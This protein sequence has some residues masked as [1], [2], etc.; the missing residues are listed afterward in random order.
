M[1]F[2][3][4]KTAVKDYCLL[5][6]TDADTRVG[7]AINRHYRRVTSR[8]GLDATR[9]VT[10]SASMTLGVATVTFTEI[11]KIAR[12][13]DTTDSTAIRLIPEVSIHD[14]RVTQPGEA[15]P[16][17]WALQATDADSVVIRTDTVPQFAWSLQADGWT[18]LS[19]LSGTDEPAFPESFHDIL[20]WY[21]IA[22]EM[23]KKEKE[24]LARIYEAKAEALFSDLQFYLA[25]SPTRDTQQ[26]M[27]TVPLTGQGGASG[28]G[29]NSGSTSYTQSG[30]LTFDRGAGIAPFVVAQSDA[31]YVANLG[32]EFLGNITTDRLIGRDTA[33]T[34]ESEQLTVGG[35]VEFTGSGG[36]QRSALTGDVTASAGSGATTIANLA[37]TTGKLDDLAVST[38]KI[39]A[40][41]VTYAKIQN[42]SATSR[43][44]GR[45]TSG[46]GD[47]EEC[48][49]SEVL[50]FISSAAQ[51]D[52]LYRGAS[53][54]ARLGA[55]TALQVLQTQGASANPQWGTGVVTL[56]RDVS[57]NEVVSTAAETTVYSYS[58]AGGT[59]ST[60]RSVRVTMIG[61][62][63]NNSGAGRDLAI[64]LKYGSTTVLTA[65]FSSSPGA[66]RGQ[67]RFNATIAAA[68]S[69]SA[70]VAEGWSVMA[71]TGD[72]GASGTMVSLP[73]S[74]TKILSGVNNAVAENSSGALTLSLTAQHNASSA[75]LSFRCHT[76][77]VEVLL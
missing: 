48:T 35:G 60:T 34:G 38:A 45:K 11:E 26:A 5:T 67:I 62:Y 52:L 73:T 61:D 22:E 6:S 64:K 76:V 30:L 49:L 3:A 16:T 21:V 42:V 55:G 28:G 31:P 46:A 54:W 24:K 13:F 1:T 27:G 17:Q 39:A 41:A 12:V 32:A 56:D 77:H 58:V 51:G 40:D 71:D 37:V 43:I 70:Q 19:D 57:Q 20:V 47:T 74:S 68:N 8:L 7:T 4:L 23:L 66:T 69:A 53:A 44:L 33:G 14:L 2:T 29:G 75:N 9:F 63:L 72:G 65:S 50:D 18:T 36:I 59:L 25:D 10:R 15:A